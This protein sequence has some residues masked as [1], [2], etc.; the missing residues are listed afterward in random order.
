MEQELQTAPCVLMVRPSNFSFNK[1]TAGDNAFQTSPSELSEDD[2][3]KLAIIEF[4]NVVEEL[5]SRGIKVLVHE[6]SE[7]PVKPDAIFPNNWLSTHRDGTIITYPMYAENR[8]LERDESLLDRI[9]ELYEV[10]KRYSFEQYEE[11]GMYL[12]GT[13]SMILDRVNNIVYACISERTS[14]ELLDKFCVL[15]DYEKLVFTATDK[16]GVRV[17][18][19]N[20]MMTIG[21]DFSVICLDTIRDEEEREMV[22]SSL[23][24]SGKEI[25]DISMEQMTA[26]AGNMLQVENKDGEAFLLMSEQARASLSD[27]QY[28]ALRERTRIASV[29]IDTIEKYGGGSIRCMLAEIFL[30][31]K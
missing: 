5:E 21:R 20:V 3:Q 25:I 15:R 13:G 12:E 22:V 4:D 8:R 9:N 24:K 27:E 10:N 16:N 31:E 14:V 17:Y 1:Q 2:I 23:K 29:K 26:Y 30:A 19:T 7:K 18:H 28:Q 11:Q 6:D